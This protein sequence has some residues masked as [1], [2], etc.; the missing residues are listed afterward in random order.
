MQ[1]NWS[2]VKCILRRH[3]AIS[4][5]NNCLTLQHILAKL[6]DMEQEIASILNLLRVK[7]SELMDLK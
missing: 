1:P 2:E 4:Q 6:G 5:A 3:E 7:Y